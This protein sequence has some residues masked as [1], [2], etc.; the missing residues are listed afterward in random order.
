M[1]P[2][3]QTLRE[4]Q[5][6]LRTGFEV[7]LLEFARVRQ[8]QELLGCFPGGRVGSL[9]LR[10]RALEARVPLRLASGDLQG[11]PGIRGLQKALRERR[12]LLA[13]VRAGPAIFLD[14]SDALA[15]GIGRMVGQGHAVEVLRK[16]AGH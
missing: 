12:V 7:D 15:V 16:V 6:P 2:A 11:R 10:S 1:I 14:N 8:R 9:V 3:G 13:C 5:H 4:L